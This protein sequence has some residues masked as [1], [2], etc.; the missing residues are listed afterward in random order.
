M[1]RQRWPAGRPRATGQRSPGSVGRVD[2]LGEPAA[3]DE[4]ELGRAGALDEPELGNSGGSRGRVRRSQR[5]GDPARAA[6]EPEPSDPD[7]RT[8]ARHRRHTGSAE[9][10]G[11]TAEIPEPTAAAIAQVL[12]PR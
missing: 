8:A 1:S 2:T 5:A 6:D 11:A 10:A 12:A 7:H 3:L 9:H 4:P